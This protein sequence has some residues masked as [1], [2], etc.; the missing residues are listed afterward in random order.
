LGASPAGAAEQG[1]GLSD[2]PSA[3]VGDD[4]PPQP[5]LDPEAPT[6]AT[7]SEAEE[8][9][10]RDDGSVAGSDQPLDSNGVVE[11]ETPSPVSPQPNEKPKKKVAAD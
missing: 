2:P 8:A 11:D 10:K 1:Q 7:T 4:A 9:D 6:V 5:D 3:L